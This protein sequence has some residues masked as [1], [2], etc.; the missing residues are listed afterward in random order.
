MSA[1][2]IALRTR[3]GSGACDT[4]WKGIGI[5]GVMAEDRIEAKTMICLLRWRMIIIHHGICVLMCLHGTYIVSSL[6]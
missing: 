1:T 5:G 3:F 6:L 4:L 2:E